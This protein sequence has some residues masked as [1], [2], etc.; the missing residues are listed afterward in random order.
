MKITITRTTIAYNCGLH[1][2]NNQ[3]YFT[4]LI[5]LPH[6]PFENDEFSYQWNLF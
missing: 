5:S 1:Y 2:K 3:I 6:M 4:T